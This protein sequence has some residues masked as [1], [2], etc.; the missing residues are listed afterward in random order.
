MLHQIM[1]CLTVAIVLT[2]ALLSPRCHCRCDDARVAAADCCNSA[3]TA[4]GSGCHTA[5]LTTIDVEPSTPGVP[6]SC[7]HSSSPAYAESIASPRPIEPST[8]CFHL[9]HRQRVTTDLSIQLEKIVVVRFETSPK[10]CSR[11]CRFLI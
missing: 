1:V 5:T 3:S 9:P 10:L 11:L 8:K 6:C 2:T 7:C 4:T